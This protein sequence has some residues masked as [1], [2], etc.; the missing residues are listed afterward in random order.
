MKQGV[1]SGI[2]FAALAIA[3]GSTTDVFPA[4]ELAAPPLKIAAFNVRVFGPTKA[5]IP[6]VMNTIA[7]VVA[8]YDII[9]IQEVRDSSETVVDKLLLEVNSLVGSNAYQKQVSDRL[10]RTASK[11]QYAFLYRPAKVKVTGT[12]QYDDGV[13]SGTD[14]FQREPYVVRFH[15]KDTEVTDFAIIAIHTDPQEAVSEIGNLTRVYDAVK[16]H[17]ALED[18]LIAGDF[19]ADCNYVN[20]DEWDH[21]SLWTDPRFK[22]LISNCFDTTV[23]ATDCAY[24]RFVG[25]GIKLLSAVV[26]NSAGIYEFD[27]GMS[28]AD[29]LAVSDHY[30]IEIQL[31]GKANITAQNVLKPKHSFSVE[32]SR[33]VSNINDIRKI[34]RAKTPDKVANFDVEVLYQKSGA[35]L[36]VVAIKTGVTIPSQHIEEFSNKFPDV[37]CPELISA[38][39]AFEDSDALNEPT[40]IYGIQMS[41]HSTYDLAISCRLQDPLTC[42]LSIQKSLTVSPPA[43][44]SSAGHL[45]GPLIG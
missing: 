35:M 21:I 31:A 36:Y 7:K 12:Y 30:P 42:S 1:V 5:S 33:S 11:E 45:H 8:R 17:W 23:T 26:H 14:P 32:C 10:G 38:A 2:I 9:L 22:W 40:P 20:G 39:H 4:P 15:A 28:K 6:A 24:D 37:L 19:N 13:D 44:T 16:Q 41:P 18:I 25:A 43:A 29:A 34:Y 3:L 27:K